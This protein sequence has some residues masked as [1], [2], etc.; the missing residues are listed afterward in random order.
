MPLVTFMKWHRKI[1]IKVNSKTWHE[2]VGTKI[3]FIFMY[4]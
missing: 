3:V 1:K 2:L 4:V